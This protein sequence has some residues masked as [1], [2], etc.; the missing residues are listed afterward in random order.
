MNA[1]L[2]PLLPKFRT[3]CEAC[4]ESAEAMLAQ[5]PELP[6]AL[7]EQLGE[8]MHKLAGSAALFG[9]SRLGDTA[10]AVEEAL[11]LTGEGGDDPATP[12]TLAALLHDFQ[13]QLARTLDN[14]G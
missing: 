5:L 2:A 11:R 10:R 1:A 4:G 6:P 9:E 13:D 14:I 8:D 3:R 7:A 12:V